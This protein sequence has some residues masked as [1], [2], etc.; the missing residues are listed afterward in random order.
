MRSLRIQLLACAALAALVRIA[1]Y[2]IGPIQRADLSLFEHARLV[3]WGTA[4]RFAE[5]L[6]VPFD[7]LPYTLIF[8]VVVAAAL[9]VGRRAEAVAAAVLMVGATVTTQLLK[10]LLAESRPRGTGQWL[11]ADAWPS[12]HTTAAAALALG[13]VLVTPPGRRRPVAVVAGVLVLVVGAA[14]VGV[15]SHYPSDIAGGLCVAAAWGCV[16]WRLATRRSRTA[17]P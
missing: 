10:P 9:R 7:P 12:G 8:A 11:P 15:G 14:L 16:A 3:P 13:L 5:A 17:T 4:H 1:A 2:D 6:V